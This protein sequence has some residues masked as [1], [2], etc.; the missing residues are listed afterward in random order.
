MRPMELGMR[1]LI[2]PQVDVCLTLKRGEWYVPFGRTLEVSRVIRVTIVPH[3]VDC[4][5]K[6]T[7]RS[8]EQLTSALG[9]QPALRFRH[10]SGKKIMRGR[11]MRYVTDSGTITRVRC[12]R[13]TIND[14]LTER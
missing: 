4:C 9:D 7:I 11:M 2:P 8:R 13:S 12:Q 14:H 5:Q 6:L 3:V 10:G 1:S